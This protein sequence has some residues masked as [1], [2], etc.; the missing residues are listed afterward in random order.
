[1][2]KYIFMILLFPVLLFSQN[3]YIGTL[4]PAYS[5]PFIAGND[6]ILSGANL[7]SQPLPINNKMG[8][9]TIGIQVDTMASGGSTIAEIAVYWKERLEGLNWGV[10]SDSIAVDSICLGTISSA[11]ITNGQVWYFKLANES[12]WGYTDEGVLVLDPGA[13]ADSLYIKCRVKGQ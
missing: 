12:W 3:N 8:A 10:P 4:I 5:V 7:T 6:T 1:M 11:N 2:K 13:T 9:I